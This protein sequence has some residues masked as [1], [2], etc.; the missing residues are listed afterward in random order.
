[1]LTFEPRPREQVCSSPARR[2][3]HAASRL[4]QADRRTDP[5]HGR[6]CGALAQPQQLTEAK[7]ERPRSRSV[8]SLEAV[9]PGRP[10]ADGRTRPRAARGRSAASRAAR[11]P[12]LRCHDGSSVRQALELIERYQPPRTSFLSITHVESRTRWRLLQRDAS[13]RRNPPPPAPGSGRVEHQERGRLPLD[14]RPPVTYAAF[15]FPEPEYAALAREMYRCDVRYGQSWSGATLPA[16]R[17]T[18]L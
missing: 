7:T 17:S 8:S 1:M 10:G 12:G 9:A 14:G 2:R 18:F 15:P 11:H 3:L 5:Q 16:T 6:G 4:H 13:A